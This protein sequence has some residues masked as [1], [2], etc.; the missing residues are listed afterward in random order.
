[1]F[2][3]FIYVSQMNAQYLKIFQNIDSINFGTVKFD[4]SRCTRFIFVDT[5]KSPIHIYQM[6]LRDSGSTFNLSS[7]NK[8]LPVV[9]YPGDTLSANICF[10]PNNL[11]PY[12]DTILIEAECLYIPVALSGRGGTGLIEATDVDFGNVLLGD[13]AHANIMISNKSSYPYTSSFPFTL[14]SFSTSDFTHFFIDPKKAPTFP[15]TIEPGHFIY[16]PYCYTPSTA[17]EDSTII[18]WNTDIQYPDLIKSSSLLKGREVWRALSWDNTSQIFITDSVFNSRITK[19]IYIQNSGT[20]LTII[21]SVSIEGVDSSEFTI[22]ANER[23]YLTLEN[24]PLAAGDYF[25]VNISFRPDITKPGSPLYADRHAILHATYA[26]NFS[27]N[28]MYSSDTKL[29]GTWATSNVDVTPSAQQLH[30]YPNPVFG[31][32]VHVTIPGNDFGTL[33]IFDVL[34]R[35]VYRKEIPSDIPEIEISLRDLMQGV[36]YVRL[37]SKNGTLAE[38]MEV[39]R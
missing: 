20:A 35:E 22:G 34:G 19:P 33:S 28:E 39:V 18:G 30:L 14:S 37:S 6:G 32:S 36:Y 1:M 11:G 17:K 27:S 12:Y 5:C 15:I 3:T 24:F 7:F 16:I 13:T 25:W 21:S 9:L 2:F 23:S 8:T 26:K 31:N 38:R 10:T 4:T 29:I